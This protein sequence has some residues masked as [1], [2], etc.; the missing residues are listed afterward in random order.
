MPAGLA[1]TSPA[2]VFHFPLTDSPAYPDG[3]NSS[4]AVSC[5]IDSFFLRFGPFESALAHIPASFG[6]KQHQYPVLDGYISALTFH[7]ALLCGEPHAV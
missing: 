3:I 1:I 4:R 2:G 6:A 7:Q 5:P